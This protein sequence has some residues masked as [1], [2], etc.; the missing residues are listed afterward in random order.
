MISFMDLNEPTNPNTK[1]STSSIGI[2]SSSAI[3]FFVTSSFHNSRNT[4][5]HTTDFSLS[6]PLGSDV[7]NLF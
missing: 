6:N 7:P 3:S 5:S 2:A 4:F 1:L